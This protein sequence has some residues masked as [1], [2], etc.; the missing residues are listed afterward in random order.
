MQPAPAIGFG[1]VGIWSSA[2]RADKPEWNDEI[3]E[4]A[5]ELES[6]GYG[7]LWIGGSPSVAQA[8]PVLE[9]TNRI[10]V[11]TGILSIWDHEAADVAAQTAEL[12]RAYPRRF[13]LGIGA[14][15]SAMSERYRRPYS[16]VRQYLDGLDAAAEPVPASRRVLA[17]LGPKML[18]LSRDRALGAHPYLVTVQHTA[19]ARRILGEG[20]LLAPEL[21]VVLNEDPVAARATARRYLGGYLA[22]PNYTTNLLRWGFTQDDFRDGG[23]HRLVDA[24]FAHGSAEAVAERVGAYLAAGADH[25]AVQVVGEDPRSDL[26]YEEWAALSSALS[27]RG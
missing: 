22:L 20:A 21:K 4:A 6:L 5:A 15:H 14:S 8:A 18:E 9:A 26:P 16:S 3:G 24:V 11:A 19:E 12:E 25:V 23:S 10:V 27:L 1:R 17:A 13:V 2:L 7:T